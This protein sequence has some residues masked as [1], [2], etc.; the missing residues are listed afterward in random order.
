[1]KDYVM[2]MR[3]MELGQCHQPKL[4]CI[5]DGSRRRSSIIQLIKF[6]SHAQLQ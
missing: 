5:I 1:M 4:L 3:T 2:H 6:T